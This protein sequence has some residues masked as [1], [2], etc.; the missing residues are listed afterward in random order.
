[1]SATVALAAVPLEISAPAVAAAPRIVAT[2]PFAAELV[3]MLVDPG[4]PVT[5]LMPNGADPH[6]WQPSA[7]DLA[8][9]HGAAV[10]VINGGGLEVHLAGALDELPTP[11]FRITEHVPLLAA[12]GHHPGEDPDDEHAHEAHDH[13]PADPHLWTDPLTMRAALA[14]LARALETAGVHVGDRLGTATAALGQLDAEVGAMLATIPPARR[15]L[16][17]G[18]ESLGYFAARYGFTVVGAV[19]PSLTSAA[20][21]N[22]A[23][24]AELVAMLRREQVD[25]VF[26]ETGAPS[27]T[28]RAIAADAGARTI[29]LETHALPA[30]GGYRQFMLDLAGTIAG[31]LA[32]RAAAGGTAVSRPS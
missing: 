4:T 20:D 26:T 25:V 8:A 28:A 10:V 5:T 1:M 29:V 12:D 27:A 11:P 24:L 2:T 30:T 31:A 18:H 14:G 19:V 6:D 22:A 17:T 9:L 32:P 16:V 23:D 3:R 21:V 13:G 7:S 15:K